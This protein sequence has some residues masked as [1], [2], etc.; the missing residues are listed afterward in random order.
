MMGITKI[1]TAAI[2]MVRLVRED[3]KVVQ[4]VH[5][6]TVWLPVIMVLLAIRRD[7]KSRDIISRFVVIGYA[8]NNHDCQ[9]VYRTISVLCA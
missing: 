8:C 9:Y 1:V 4:P 3:M 5:H 7:Q 2:I 6:H